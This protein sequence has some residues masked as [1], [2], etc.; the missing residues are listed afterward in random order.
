MSQQF[1]DQH[2]Q[3]HRQGEPA[4]GPDY[5]EDEL[6]PEQGRAV[7][8]DDADEAADVPAEELDGGSTEE[9]L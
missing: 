9:P 4:E 8:D 6:G 2:Q 3:H 5:E 7:R 1:P